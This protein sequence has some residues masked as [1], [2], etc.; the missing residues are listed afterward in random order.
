MQTGLARALVPALALV[1]TAAF[2]HIGV[3]DGQGF[4]RGF[5]HPLGGLDHVL[6]MV[7]LGILAWQIGGRALLLLP[8]S[9]VLVMAAG[10]MLAII[11][12]TLPGI[13]IGLA[14][15]VI[16]LGTLV[17]FG[18]RTPLATA[19]ALAGLFALFHGHAHGVEMPVGAL[20][21]SYGA[22]FLSATAVL[23]GCGIALASLVGRIAAAPGDAAFRL[24]GAGIA[25]CGFVLLTQP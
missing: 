13:E 21:A 15:S 20:A 18:A 4:G 22:G 24:G 14:L 19:S 11:G 7:A 16:V 17:T 10:A 3:D 6:A 9:F 25:I 23:H 1:P 12:S 5:A 8:A 2:A